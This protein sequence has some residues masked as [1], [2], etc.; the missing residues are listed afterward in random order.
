MKWRVSGLNSKVFG[1]D[2]KVWNLEWRVGRCGVQKMEWV[3][4][5]EYKASSGQCEVGSVK[6]KV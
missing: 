4:C 5:V 3:E 6:C 2:C 1:V